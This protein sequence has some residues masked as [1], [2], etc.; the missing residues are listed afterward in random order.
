MS[1]RRYTS[2]TTVFR[3]DR[4]NIWLRFASPVRKRQLDR[5]RSLVLFAPHSIFALLRWERSRYGTVLSHITIMRT[6]APGEPC[7]TWP[8]VHPGAELLLFA[9]GWLKVERVLQA[10]DAVEALDIDPAD[11][12]P[13]YWQ[14]LH[15]SLG[16]RQPPH[17]YS[18]EQHRAWLRRHELLS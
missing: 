8:N 5:R 4:I 17:P 1:M 7:A 3:P 12:A 10:I 2:V 9:S 18:A 6:V 16:V 11:A 14:H 13:E 15:N